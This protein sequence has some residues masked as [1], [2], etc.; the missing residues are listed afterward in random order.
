MADGTTIQSNIKHHSN[1]N[2]TNYALFVGGLNVT[3]EVLQ[4]YD[5]LR[6]GYGRLFMVR[7]PKWVDQYIPT[8]MKKFKHIL[9]YGNTAVQ[10]I[11]DIEVN[12][13]DYTGGY[14]GKSFSI[15]SVATDGTQTFT[16]NCYEF[17]GSPI[18]EVVHTWVNGTT[19]LLTGLT[20]YNGKVRTDK[21]D[22]LEALQSNQTAEFVYVST[23]VTGTQVEY[24]CLF[25]N[26]FPSNVRNEQF[27][28]TSGSH[29]LVEYNVEFRCTKYESMQ[30]NKLGQTLL[31]KYKVLANSL[32]F[33]SGIKSTSL[34][35]SKH[36]EISTGQLVSGA[37][38][39]TMAPMQDTDLANL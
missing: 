26:C 39:D 33:F 19:D 1:D 10:G 17:S 15:P 13:N 25:A 2:L 29:E 35:D 12:F 24:A 9:E 36:Y 32:N 38:E 14:A 22:G 20:H 8:K 34:T 3:N 23:D 16:V 5:P 30:I 21:K 27:N 28:Y 11:G 6:T 37:G 4:N 7:V 31:D 18:R